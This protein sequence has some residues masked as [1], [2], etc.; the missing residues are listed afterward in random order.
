MSAWVVV[1]LC[2]AAAV[3]GL[4]AGGVLGH[5][6]VVVMAQPTPSRLSA[7]AVR[8]AGI[9]GAAV[10]FVGEH[11]EVLEATDAAR[12][13]GLVRGTRLVVPEVL[14][15]VR[16]SR[17]EQNAGHLSL[18]VPRGQSRLT[19][20][21]EV[22]VAA[23]DPDVM[24]VVARDETEARRI[25]ESRRDFVTNISHELKTPI[26]AVALLS[27]A[28]ESAADDP[29]MVAHFAARLHV[30]AARL[31]ELVGQIITLSRLQSDDPLHEP[32]PADV[33]GIV[34]QAVDRLTAR[35]KARRVTITVRDDGPGDVIGDPGQLT[36]AVAN[37][38]TNAIAYSHEGARV[39]VTS[40]RR[41][42][43]GDD[44][45][46]I[47]VTDNGIGIPESERERIFE[48]FYRVDPDRSRASGGTGLGLSIVR[49]VAEAHGGTVS[50]WSQP[51][52]GSTFTLRLPARLSGQ[53]PA[54]PE[55]IPLEAS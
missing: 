54:Q 53:P 49:L 13:L 34:A 29:E 10:V 15:L 5:R 9:A 26:G 39:A 32:V 46:E 47:A 38:V 6:K 31:S 14:E 21:L 23:L 4:V 43:D 30:E 24:V 3:L 45:V 33:S 35:A 7:P 55:P 25:H 50:V 22:T 28:V 44:W 27:E 12:N 17:R 40:T 18:E 19:T 36:D 8:V 37:L 42:V 51:G 2:L 52:H 48:R 20:H 11:D 16:A 41:T 1:L